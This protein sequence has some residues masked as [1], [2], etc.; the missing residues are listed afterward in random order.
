[1]NS[2]ASIEHSTSNFERRTEKQ[3]LSSFNVGRSLFNVRCSIFLAILLALPFQTTAT[4][5]PQLTFSPRIYNFGTLISTNTVRLSIT[6][7]NTGNARLVIGN[8]VGCCGASTKISRYELEAGSTAILDIQLPLSEMRGPV[9]KNIFIHSNDPSLPVTRI[10]FTGIAVSLVDLSP[11]RIDFGS[12][13]VTDRIDRV[14]QIS[15]LS[16]IAFRVTNVTS[17]LKAFSAVCAAGSSPDRHSIKISTEPLMSAG[18]A[19]GKIIVLTD[20]AGYPRFE[21]PVIARVDGEA[22]LDPSALA[23]PV[24]GTQASSN[25]PSSAIKPV[26]ISFF[27][28]PGC[29]DCRAVSNEVLPELEARCGGLYSLEFRDVGI[30]SNYLQLVQYQAQLGVRENESVC[31][32][33][34]GRFALNGL[35]FIQNR[36]ISTVEQCIQEQLAGIGSTNH[37]LVAQSPDQTGRAILESRMR[38]FTLPMVLVAGFLD[39]L[40]PCAFST[41]V[42]FMSLLAVA[43][44]RGRDLALMGLAFGIG[45]FLTY[46][47]LGFGL[48]RALRLLNGF[49]YARLGLEVFMIGLLGLLA[50]LSF[51]DAYLFKRSGNPSDVALQIPDR[52][53]VRMHKLMRK[54]LAGPSLLMG[55]L[56]V[57]SAVTVLE[58]VCTGQLYIPTMALIIKDSGPGSE[59][60]ST[61]WIYLLL[62]NAMFIVPLAVVFAFSYFGL[63]MESLLRWSKT[64]VAFSKIM[65]GLLFLMLAVLMA[66]SP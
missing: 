41:L 57:S 49:E 30:E 37:A 7:T 15:S 9:D 23:T 38:S 50:F 10:K 3:F 40:N 6:L 66:V 1:M 42:F 45:T 8:I 48:L 24:M 20:H 35:K 33:I 55:G 26:A 5:S 17:S 28:Q 47:A 43:R 11:E 56:L 27:Y 22:A 4:E 34:D 21:I 62:Y 18:L 54:G 65:L 61:A 60:A 14:V 51:R 64:N 36:L 52:I 44:V 53:K 13:T 2:G 59:L 63:R 31:M 25:I 39:G 16:N 58:S 12:I 19:N 29:K 46:T 32:I